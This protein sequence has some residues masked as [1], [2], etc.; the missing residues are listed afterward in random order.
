MLKLQQLKIFAVLVVVVLGMGHLAEAQLVRGFVSGT[1]T[2]ATNAIV[3]GVQVTVTNKATGISRETQSNYEGFYRLV[4][5]EPGEYSVE[6]K[7]AGFQTLK[8]ES[9]S[10]RTA[11]EV[12][13]NQTLRVSGVSAEVSVIE[14][15]GLEL[16]KTTATVER[17]F[18]MREI[19]CSTAVRSAS[20]ATSPVNSTVRP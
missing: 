17:T 10:V 20:L 16:A 7:L 1:V 12:V 11:Q 19:V 8:I 18:S 4:A 3:P 9:I 2:D 13:L 5:L 15:P 14:T 6:F